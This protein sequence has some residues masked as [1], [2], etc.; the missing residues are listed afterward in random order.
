MQS[1]AICYEDLPDEIRAQIWKHRTIFRKDA[2]TIIFRN[3]AKH[4]NKMILIEF[5]ENSTEYHIDEYSLLWFTDV[6][7]RCIAEYDM[8][9]ATMTLGEG[10]PDYLSDIRNVKIDLGDTIGET[11]DEDT[12]E[13]DF[14]GDILS[15]RERFA[16]G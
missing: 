7:G 13:T 8:K 14:S 12:F 4:K 6:Y 9:N 11:L 15:A 3:L 2:A 1:M 10:G 5:S 16:E